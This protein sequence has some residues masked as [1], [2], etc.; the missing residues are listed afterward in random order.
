MKVGMKDKSSSNRRAE[1]NDR[2]SSTLDLK[3]VTGNTQG[4]AQIKT[5]KNKVKCRRHKSRK[6][7]EINKGLELQSLHYDLTM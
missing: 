7:K 3:L 6:C 1:N 4:I 5:C 2:N